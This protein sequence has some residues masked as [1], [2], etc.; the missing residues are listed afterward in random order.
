EKIFSYHSCRN[1]S[2][3]KCHQAQTERW[4]EKQ[5]SRLPACSYFLVTFTLS[6]ELRPLA[7]NPSEENLQPADEGRRRCPTEARGRSPVSGRAPGYS[8]RPSH[9][10]ARHEVCPAC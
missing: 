5:R 1:R 10:D 4:I 8:G 9:L 7:T 2:R 6:A 3:P